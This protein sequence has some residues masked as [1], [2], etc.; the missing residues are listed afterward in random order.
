MR[1]PALSV[2][3]G[4]DVGRCTTPVSVGAVATGAGSSEH[5]PR[6]TT[7]TRASAGSRHADGLRRTVIGLRP[8][9]GREELVELGHRMGGVG[10]RRA[11][12]EQ[13]DAAPALD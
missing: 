13:V 12:R 8:G 1:W 3:G 7:A 4:A 6:P 10:L 11:Q 9:P 5:P 2:V